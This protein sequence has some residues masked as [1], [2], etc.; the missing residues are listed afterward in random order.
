MLP[1]L[2]QGDFSAMVLP[3]KGPTIIWLH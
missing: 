2:P 3:L 1:P